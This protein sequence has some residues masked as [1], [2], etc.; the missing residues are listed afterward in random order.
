MINEKFERSSVPECGAPSPRAK[1]Q[2]PVSTNPKDVIGRTKPPLEL[3]PPSF[4]ILTSMAMKLGAKKYGPYNWRH[5]KVSAMVYLGAA[6]RHIQSAI[7]GEEIDHES[8]VSHIAH[9]SACMAIFLDAQATGN[10]VDDRPPKGKAA[11]LIRGLTEKATEC[12]P[13]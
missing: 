13:F 1:E 3:V 11:E 4:L 12:N 6:L 9:A 8:G 10:M 5:E 2:Q 7:D